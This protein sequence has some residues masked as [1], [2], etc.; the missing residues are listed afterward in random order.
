M[1]IE[2]K[3]VAIIIDDFSNRIFTYDKT[4]L[5]EAGSIDVLTYVD[6]Y[7]LDGTTIDGYGDF[8]KE[9]PQST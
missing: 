9:K 2:Y 6:Y 5:Y 8:D 7:T 4:T 1:A 3:P